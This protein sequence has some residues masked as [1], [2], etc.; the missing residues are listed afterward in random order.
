MD[1]R[2]RRIIPLELKHRLS[3][4]MILELK[5]VQH[6]EGN[7]DTI[8]L[9]KYQGLEVYNALGESINKFMEEANKRFD[10]PRFLDF[11]REVEDFAEGKYAYNKYKDLVNFVINEDYVLSFNT[12]D[13][14]RVRLY[15]TT[16]NMVYH[17]RIKIL[18]IIPDISMYREVMRKMYGDYSNYKFN[19]GGAILLIRINNDDEEDIEIIPMVAERKFKYKD[20]M[21]IM[22][23]IERIRVED[24]GKGM[25][26]VLESVQVEDIEKQYDTSK[27]KNVNK[28]E[29]MFKQTDINK[30]SEPNV[31]KSK[32]SK[33]EGLDYRPSYG[34]EVQKPVEPTLVPAYN[35]RDNNPNHI[36]K[37]EVMIDTNSTPKENK[38]KS[39]R[40]QLGLKV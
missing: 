4:G 25:L 24:E 1:K 37:E 26:S 5:Q 14:N 29:L 34:M 33:V 20:F 13:I 28:E 30:M 16:T 21:A 18:E 23:E 12:L 7:R 11:L 10:N 40:E 38:P 9:D 35:S 6:F 31:L 8:T 36:R 32:E 15:N 39:L 27:F 2:R 22:K 3:N 19:K 17:N